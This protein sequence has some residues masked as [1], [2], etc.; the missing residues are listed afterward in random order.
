MRVVRQREPRADEPSVP[1]EMDTVRLLR[2][3]ARG[4]TP[5]AGLLREC[6]SGPL[7]SPLNGLVTVTHVRHI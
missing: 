6:S 7:T 1:M 3:C 5:R 4:V 2:K